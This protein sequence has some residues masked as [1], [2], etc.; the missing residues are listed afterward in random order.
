MQ[1]PNFSTRFFAVCIATALSAT[2]CFAKPDGDACDRTDHAARL[3]HC[4]DGGGETPPNPDD[5]RRNAG[6]TGNP[7]TFKIR[8]PM[9]VPG[10]SAKLELIHRLSRQAFE[11]EVKLPIQPGSAIDLED[12]A[13]AEEAIVSL[14]LYRAGSTTPY[15]SCNLDLAAIKFRSFGKTAEYAVKVNNRKGRDLRL[16]QGFCAVP[17]AAA[18][19]S[20][21]IPEVAYGVAITLAITVGELPPVLLI[22]Q[23]PLL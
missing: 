13:A 4:R 5:D 3:E 7:E 8:L 12:L 23:S 22:D 17:G 11:A 19:A 18:P 10:S 1:P 14:E 6:F 20:P 21:I 9:Q 15:A 2:A 16:R